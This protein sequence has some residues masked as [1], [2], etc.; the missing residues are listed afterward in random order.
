[1]RGRASAKKWRVRLLFVT[2]QTFF[3]HQL[4]AYSFPQSVRRAVEVVVA[5][6]ARRPTSQQ[7]ALI[8]A[9]WASFQTIRT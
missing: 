2:V 3:T 6:P 5:D 1:M 7:S 8:L 4:A 9:R